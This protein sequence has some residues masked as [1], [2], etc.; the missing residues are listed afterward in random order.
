[1]SA[2]S[3]HP[4]AESFQTPEFRSSLTVICQWSKQVVVYGPHHCGYSKIAHAIN[5]DSSS[6]VK[7][8]FTWS[9]ADPLVTDDWSLK[10]FEGRKMHQLAFEPGYTETIG[11]LCKTGLTDVVLENYKREKEDLPLIPVLFCIDITDNPRPFLPA[12]ILSKVDGLNGQITHK[13]IRRA[14]KLCTHPNA[15][16]RRIALQT[17][18][19][20]KLN[21]GEGPSSLKQIPAPWAATVE[22]PEKVTA[23]FAAHWK[24]R[25]KYSIS[26]PK[27]AGHDW[28]HRL[29]KQI[30]D[31]DQA[32]K[33]TL[34]R[35]T[36]APARLDT[37][38]RLPAC[39]PLLSPTDQTD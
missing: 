29:E 27:H 26:E 14:F 38:A 1:M 7:K 19:F 33:P 12:A 36:S 28:S 3:L 21:V 2:S 17:F 25:K 15:D 4:T 5:M 11:R 35:S 13:E 22:S 34:L 16:I 37:P 23:T 39:S 31:Y 10:T 9:I 18:K 30:A 32:T 24:V 8:S 20:V 6:I